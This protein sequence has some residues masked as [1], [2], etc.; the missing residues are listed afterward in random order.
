MHQNN[1]TSRKSLEKIASIIIKYL[2]AINAQ[3]RHCICGKKIGTSDSHPQRPPPCLTCPSPSLVISSR[4]VVIT[5]ELVRL[6]SARFDLSRLV[7][8]RFGSARL[9]SSR[10][11]WF[12]SIR[13]G[14]IRS[15]YIPFVPLQKFHSCSVEKAVVSYSCKCE[16][17][18]DNLSSKL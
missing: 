13:L 17:T 5:V 9:G 7:L 11:A 8:A 15:T 3:F 4:N 18:I 14:L 16:S 10:L 2:L 6:C 1:I 12:I